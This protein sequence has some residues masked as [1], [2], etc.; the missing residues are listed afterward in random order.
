MTAQGGAGRSGPFDAR[1]R[2][3]APALLGRLRA[4]NS[5]TMNFLLWDTDGHQYLDM[6][7]FLELTK[8][9]ERPI[10]VWVTLIPP[11]E[12]VRFFPPEPPPGSRCATC[13][14]HIANP[15]GD[16]T[17][18]TF[19]CNSTVSGG[20]CGAGVPVCCLRP[21]SRAGC[22]G[23][24]RCGSN[25]QNRSVCE[26]SQC[27]VP[28]DSPLTG[29][30]ESALVDPSL[31]FRGCNDFVGWGKV[32]SQLA[33]VYPAVKAANIDDFVVSLGVFNRSYSAQIRNAL[34]GGAGLS[35]GAWR[36]NLDQ[37]RILPHISSSLAVLFLVTVLFCSGPAQEGAS[38][39]SR[40]STT[41]LPGKG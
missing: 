11:S 37:S 33:G 39:S 20:S 5:N 14:R 26:V 4:T 30:N 21:G 25:A 9:E 34:H 13:P 8:G 15:Y 41:G 24:P 17:H 40:L 38:S 35:G 7:R 12:T 1:G 3:D 22:Q 36:A 29:F 2:L 10:D 31:G 28:A 23:V 27:S 16:S 6:V 32:L 19:C 18:G